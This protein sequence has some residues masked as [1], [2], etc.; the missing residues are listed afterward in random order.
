[1]IKAL[2]INL[3]RQ[4]VKYLSANRFVWKEKMFGRKEN[5]DKKDEY[6]AQV[7]GQTETD[8]ESISARHEDTNET[9]RERERQGGNE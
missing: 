9:F 6:R 2:K 1:M 3:K 5:H 7:F 8:E 4:A